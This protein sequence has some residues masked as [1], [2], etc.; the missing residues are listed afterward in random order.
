M[1]N[2]I[3]DLSTISAGVKKSSNKTGLYRFCDEFTKSFH[4]LTPTDISISYSNCY[5]VNNLK[6]CQQYLKENNFNGSIVTPHYWLAKLY[7]FYLGQ[8]PRLRNFLNGIG[9]NGMGSIVESC[10]QLPNTIFYSPVK[11]IP[12][13]LNSYPKIKKVITLHDIIYLKYKGEPYLTEY[14]IKTLQSLGNNYGVCVSQNTKND[15]C[16]YDKNI[17]P[18]QLFV[19]HVGASNKFYPNY[20]QEQFKRIKKKYKIPDL[21]F[22]SVCTFEPRKNLTTLIKCF[23]QFIQQEKIM[24]ISL[25][26]VGSINNFK[27]N[28]F[29]SIPQKYKDKII[30][31]GRIED[32]DLSILYTQARSFYFLSLYE[33]F[34]SPPL[35]AMQCGVPVVVSNTSSLPEVVEDNGIQVDPLDKDAI[36]ETMK[37]LYANSQLVESLKQKSLCQAK[38]FS[39]NKMTE[40]YLNIFRKISESG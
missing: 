1:I 37:N 40:G 19:L 26:L 12:A 6:Y 13:F 22:L 4:H 36:C 3:Y 38:K 39:Y 33:G 11:P 23:I 18:D 27:H 16:N 28:V 34:G 2:L 17:H 29:Q 30:I 21:Y 20:N 7:P 9:L 35:E 31:T 10:L 5:I 32:D 14:T 8:Y 25:V 15:I 24:D